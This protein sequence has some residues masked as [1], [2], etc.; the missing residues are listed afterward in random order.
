M[1][2]RKTY[3]Q[4]EVDTCRYALKAQ[5]KSYSDL[6]EAEDADSHR[7]FS[8]AFANNM[9]LVLDRYFVHRLRASTGKDCNPLNEVELLADAIINHKGVLQKSTVIKYSADESV[10]HI[11]VGEAVDI[12]MPTFRRL[13]E[14][15]LADL[16]TKFVL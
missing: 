4:G 12:S 5:L 8:T 16:E 1:L 6:V 9:I 7:T 15:F 3:T 10:T 2:G 13:S 11:C 14:A